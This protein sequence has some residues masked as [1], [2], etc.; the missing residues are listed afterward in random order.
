MKMTEEEEQEEEK[1]S[2]DDVHCEIRW[3]TSCV[4]FLCGLS[5]H[6][7]CVEIGI[8]SCE[9][10]ILCNLFLKTMNYELGV[11]ERRRERDEYNDEKEEQK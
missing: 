9:F 5:F 6:W 1:T 10:N 3:V 7:N 11:Q 4:W 8:I 2:D